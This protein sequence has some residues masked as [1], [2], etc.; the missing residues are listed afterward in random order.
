MIRFK[1][2]NYQGWPYN[3]GT[4]SSQEDDSCIAPYWARIDKQSF[5]DGI[6]FVFFK[7]YEDRDDDPRGVFTTAADY[8]KKLLDVNNYEPAWVMTV[9][10]KDLRPLDAGTFGGVST[11][12]LG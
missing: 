2:G 11:I 6:S 4:L 12:K 1:D 10:W 9:T 3:F 7:K 5:V 8:A